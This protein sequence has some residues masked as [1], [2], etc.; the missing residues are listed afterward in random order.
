MFFPVTL[1]YLY[2]LYRKLP[3][4]VSSQWIIQSPK[5]EK[6]GHIVANKLLF[7]SLRLKRLIDQV[8]EQNLDASKIDK[9]AS[10]QSILRFT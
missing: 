8:N 1:P 2:A 10:Q 7:L 5:S 9:N 6:H 4:P 3:I